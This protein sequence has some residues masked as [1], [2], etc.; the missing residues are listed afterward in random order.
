MLGRIVGMLTAGAIGAGNARRGRAT[1]K[2][3]PKL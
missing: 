1:R 2:H 3:T